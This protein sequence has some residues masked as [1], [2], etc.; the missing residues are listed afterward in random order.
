MTGPSTE[1]RLM[2]PDQ[3][4]DTPYYYEKG[5]AMF[6]VDCRPLGAVIK[7]RPRRALPARA[8]DQKPSAR[9]LIGTTR[10]ILHFH[11]ELGK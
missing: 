7:E 9:K 8:R 5:T 1:H 3:S 10:W 6:C 11:G 2:S 4:Q